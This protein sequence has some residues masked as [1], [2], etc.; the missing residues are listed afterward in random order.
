MKLGLDLP[1]YWPDMRVPI[2]RLLPELI[3]VAQRGD[4]IGFSSLVLAEHHFIDYF[5]MPAPLMLASHLAALT[6]RARI[7]TSVIA[8]PFHD[9]RILAGEIAVADH[10]TKGR[11]EIGFGSGGNQYEFERMGLPWD[12]T[13]IEIFDEKLKALLVLLDGR[14]IAYE[15]PRLSFPSLTIMPP[16]LQKPHPPVW[17]AAVRP[18]AVYHSARKGFN[19]QT[20]SLRRPF[21]VSKELVQAFRTGAR[22]AGAK[23]SR[24]SFGHWVYVAKDD[25]DIGKT[26]D[27][28]LANHRRFVNLTT[29]PGIVAGGE[30]EPIAISDTVETLKNVVIVGTANYCVEKLLELGELGMDQLMVRMHFGPSHGDIMRSLDRFGEHV[31]PRLAGAL[32]P[33]R[34]APA[35][36]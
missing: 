32:R 4:E 18:E 1:A 16:P 25:S 26:L 23:S 22:E 27:L 6:K 28:A 12:K 29:T 3:E 35:A 17:I 36:G 34:S 21:A 30:V 13:R 19:V 8:L 7:I 24:I 33:D 5:V 10:L 14:D 11:L 31:M 2:E 20:A 9:V 15:T